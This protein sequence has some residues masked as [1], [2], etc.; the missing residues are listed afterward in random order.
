VRYW[1]MK[2]EPDVYSIADLKKD[3]TTLWEC[4]RNYQARNFMMND[5]KP[6][7]RVLFYHSNA[8]PSAVAGLATVAGP[9]VPDPTQFQK[10]GEY[11]DPKASP[12]KPRW[13]CV[14]VRYE[15]RFQDPISLETLKDHPALTK[16]VLL[17]NSRLSVQPVTASEFQ[18]ILKLGKALKE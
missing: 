1:L 9:A 10:A 7:D 8:S 3:G 18:F 12:A 16:M 11:F 15:G 17:N 5:M 2:S 6:G 14:P 13:F 4:V